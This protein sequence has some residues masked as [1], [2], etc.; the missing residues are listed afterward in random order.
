MHMTRPKSSKGRS[1]AR[2]TLGLEDGVHQGHV[3]LP[4]PPLPHPP[5]LSSS[6]EVSPRT[7]LRQAGRS[8]AE[9]LTE[10]FAEEET[11]PVLNFNKYKVLPSI[12]KRPE[13]EKSIRGAE[14][15]TSSLSLSD[16][17]DHLHFA[18]RLC[19]RSASRGDS[20]TKRGSEEQRGPPAAADTRR[21][22]RGHSE[23]ETGAGDAHLL[24]AIRT[25]RGQR[26]KCHFQP[27]DTLQTVVAAAQLQ[28]GE[29][30]Q[31]AV[32]ETM[33]VPRQTFTNLTRSLSQCGICNK[34]LLIISLEDSA[35]D[36]D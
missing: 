15:K 8:S 29:Q 3:F 35:V 7:V 25:P 22:S 27:T 2:L 26:F 11:L 13:A 23:S 24:L 18:Q 31:H 1:R 28:S 32:I 34:S 33:E 5:P 14:E 17:R 16:S 10:V 19:S 20:E 30:Y 12:E 21:T 9:V 4:H 36:S 6:T